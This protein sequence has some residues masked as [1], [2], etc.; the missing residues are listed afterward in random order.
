MKQFF[1]AIYLVFSP[2]LVFAVLSTNHV[3]MS[4]FIGHLDIV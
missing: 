2:D 1:T 3:W 4:G